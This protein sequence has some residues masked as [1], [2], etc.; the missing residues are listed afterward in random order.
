M[1]LK[2]LFAAVALCAVSAVAMAMPLV[3]TYVPTGGNDTHVRG[4]KDQSG[5][6]TFAFADT[7]KAAPPA[8]PVGQGLA[9]F[10][11]QAGG[12]HG[13]G[14]GSGLDLFPETPLPPAQGP[15][16]DTVF[17]GPGQDKP[18]GGG[19]PTV[20]PPA[21]AVPEPGSLALLGLG[22]SGLALLRRGRRTQR[23]E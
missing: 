19:K 14:Q 17:N 20:L 10:P 12:G 18:A 3:V 13:P 1:H 5:H 4:P 11:A 15:D 6:Y 9:H 23:R 8:Q 2:R 22:L 7:E 21:Q 16:P